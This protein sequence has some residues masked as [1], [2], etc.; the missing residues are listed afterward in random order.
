SGP[1][2]GSTGSPLKR[3]ALRYACQAP[4][5]FAFGLSRPLCC[6]PTNLCFSV[7]KPKVLRLFLLIEDGRQWLSRKMGDDG[8]RVLASIQGRRGESPAGSCDR[9]AGNGSARIVH[10]IG[11]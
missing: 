8:G 3:N 4:S 11:V 6:C 9:A 1:C 2:G 5:D 10:R 7:D